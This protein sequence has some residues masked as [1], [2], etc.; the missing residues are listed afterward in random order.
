MSVTSFI[1]F[2]AG[3][4]FHSTLPDSIASMIIFSSQTICHAISLAV[5]D[6]GSGG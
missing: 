5:R 4:G 1:V 6:L 3:A 2:G